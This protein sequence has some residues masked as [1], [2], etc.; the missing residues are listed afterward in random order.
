MIRIS[1]LVVL[2][3]ASALG[4]DLPNFVWYSTDEGTAVPAFIGV[5]P[6]APQAA[7]PDKIKF[8]LYTKYNKLVPDEIQNYTE[9]IEM[10]HWDS[11]APVKIFAHGFSSKYTSGSAGA[12]KAAIIDRDYP[13][14]TNLIL[15]DWESLAAAPWYNIA[16][17]GTRLV[18]HKS[19][20]LLHF[21]VSNGFTTA[22]KIHFGGH[23][24]G[25]HVAGFGG[26]DFQAL[27]NGDK[28]AR[29]TALDP[30][31]PGFGTIGDDSRIDSTDAT[32]VDVIHTS[33][34]TIF[35]GELAFLEP[36]GHADFYPNKGRN[37]P[38]CLEIV[39]ECSHS[40]CYEYY[41]ESVQS[42]LFTACKCNDDAW[43]PDT[44]DKFSS[45]DC[46]KGSAK[47]GEWTSGAHGVYY[48]T[49]NSRKPF[50]QG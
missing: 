6:V 31:L 10:S 46:A 12:I 32:F 20:Y 23:S 40:R 41:S 43:D 22:D 49:T 29:I 4:K 48:L 47:M 16:A 17:E 37:Q 28:L 24:L 45:C 44:N 14:N 50:A 13:G 42:D 7:D 21:L 25:A 5:D 26:A 18:G 15:V 8:F 1:L 11:H 27:Q 39:G 34:G 19:A 38:G 30:A 2:L 35:E 9:S 36:R 3:A 33:S